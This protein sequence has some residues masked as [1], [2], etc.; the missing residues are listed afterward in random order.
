LGKIFVGSHIIHADAQDP[1]AEGLIEIK[2]SLMPIHLARSDG[3]KG[4]R[5]ESDDQ[6]MLPIVILIIIY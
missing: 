4:S 2:V 3:G 6:M 5:E 1:G